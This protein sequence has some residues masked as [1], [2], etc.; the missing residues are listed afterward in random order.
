M[1]KE[2]TIRTVIIDDE[3][4]AVAALKTM[5]EDFCEG[6]EIIGT[7]HNALEGI[8]VINRTQPDLVFLDIEM[9][10]G[11]GFELLKNISERTF[12]VV[13]VTA[14]QQYAIKA[15]KASAVDYLLKPVDLDEL[16][17]ALDRIRER[18]AGAQAPPMSELLHNLSTTNPT[19]LTLPTS[20]GFRYVN[21][22]DIIRM[23]AQGSYSYI[24]LEDGEHIL[25]SKN[26]KAYE[27]LVEGQRFFRVHHSH[28]VN[29]DHVQQFVRA[30]GGYLVMRDGARVNISRAKKD[31]ILALLG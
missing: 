30:D 7:A 4:D 22:E 13:F 1:T 9:P 8:G 23:E 11:N 16:E 14:F 15:I 31:Q 20:D 2:T 12:Q 18:L 17:A 29:L 25:V 10:H 5:L 24:V 19:R 27:Q 3:P 21:I 28:L 6:V 26:L